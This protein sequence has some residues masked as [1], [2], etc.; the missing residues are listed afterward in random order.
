VG[1]GF[2]EA[3]L[4]VV[5]LAAATVVAAMGAA[6]ILIVNGMGL[7]RVPALLQTGEAALNL[8]LS[9]ALGL[10]LGLTGVALATL[11]ASALVT[12]LGTL[13]YACRLVG[14]SYPRLLG[15]AL[16]GHLPPAVAAL[17]AGL[18]L[19]G[20]AES[21]LL[22]VLVAGITVV[23]VYVAVLLLT[24]LDSRERD[25]VIGLRRRGRVEAG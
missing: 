23:A 21:G 2:G 15:G 18:A 11:I 14:I 8:L 9:I 16:L 5:Y 3:R 13:P 1:S 10:T 17:L 12:F 19:G 7:P 20:L 6:A 24:G 4:V 25:R 22:G